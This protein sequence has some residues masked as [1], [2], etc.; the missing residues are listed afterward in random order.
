MGYF[1]EVLALV[2]SERPNLYTVLAFLRA[3]GL[4]DMLLVMNK[5]LISV[6]DPVGNLVLVIVCC[7][8]STVNSY[9]HVGMVS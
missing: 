1:C 3:I 2:H 5:R 7:F 9:G 8:T 4:K 6:G